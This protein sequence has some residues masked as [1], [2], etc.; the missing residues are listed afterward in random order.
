MLLKYIKTKFKE[1]NFKYEPPN[2]D[3]LGQAHPVAGSDLQACGS[4]AGQAYVA[5]PQWVTAGVLVTKPWVMVFQ[6][7]PREA[8]SSL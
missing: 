7:N 8:T 6:S 5:A 4:N 1:S 3:S 2:K